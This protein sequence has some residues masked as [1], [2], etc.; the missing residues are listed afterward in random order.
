MKEWFGKKKGSGMTVLVS[1]LA[2]FAVLAAPARAEVKLPDVFSDNMVL[3]RE[4]A[5]PVWGTADPGEKVSVSFNGQSASATAGKDG[6]WMLRLKK[7][8][9]G[10][11]FDLT[12]SGTNTVTYRNVLVGEVWLCSGQSNMWWTIDR[13]TGIEPIVK[14]ANYPTLRVFQFWTPENDSFGKRPTWEVCSPESIKEFS[15]VA[16]FYGKYLSEEL[17]VPVGLIHSS[18]GGSV[19]ET[20]MTRKT[21][22]SD[23]E[24]RPIIAYWD[25]LMTAYPGA[26]DRYVRYLDELA[27]QKQ[28]N[29]PAPKDPN[30]PFLPKP[31]RFSMLYPTWLYGV[32]LEPL[33]PFG[34][35]GVIWFQGESSM[36]RAAQYRRLFPA[37][38]KEWR[39]IWGQGDFPFIYAQLANCKSNPRQLP[40]LREMQRLSLSVKNTAMA[41]TVDIGDES[42]VHFNNKWDVGRR[43]ALAAFGTVYGRDIV[44]SGPMYRSMQ[45]EGNA[46]RLKFDHRA[47][48]METKDGA[49]L[50][51]FIIAG[52][53]RVFHTAE[54]KFSGRDILVSSKEVPD[55]VAVRYGWSDIPK[56]N[57]ANDA[58]LPA[59]PFRTDN[60]PLTTEGRLA[61]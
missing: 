43:L 52:K 15:A 54:A 11:P 4:Q 56:C 51:E 18:M 47:G 34:M 42:N 13:I 23:K 39:N 5:V 22:Q 53:D 10:G 59:S 17:G 48:G 50:R 9:A 41:V 8:T 16:F 44:Y 35:R 29:G 27:R 55:P 37:M 24:F 19:P 21:L 57:L 40:E 26:K 46:I 25:S 32:Q 60:W 6:R 2:A 61:P 12:V 45:K 1:T 3:Q 28:E 49:P 30:L 33:V 31:F 20:W 58:G 14:A 7:M 38:I 36:A